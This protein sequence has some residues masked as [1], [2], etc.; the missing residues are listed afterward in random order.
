MVTTLTTLL[1]GNDAFELVRDQIAL[2]IFDNAAAQFALAVGESDPSLWALDVYTERST[3]WEAWLNDEAGKTPIVNV[4]FESA[5]VILEQSGPTCQIYDGLF[6]VDCYGRGIAEDDPAAGPGHTP[7]D[8]AAI[9][10]ATRAAKLCRRFLMAGENLYLQLRRNAVGP[11]GPAVTKRMVSGIASLG[12][13]ETASPALR[14]AAYRLSVAVQYREDVPLG[15]ESNE[16]EYIAADIRRNI[17][18]KL[19]GE[20]DF[21]LTL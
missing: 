1:E 18:G 3:A 20:A 12:V 16:L 6:H 2:L 4:S 9:I 15:D 17:D 8:L 10:A 11:T 21:D 5:N 14:V 19:I 7:G 13:N